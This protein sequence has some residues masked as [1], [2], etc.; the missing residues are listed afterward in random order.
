MFRSSSTRRA[1]FGRAS[2]ATGWRRPRSRRPSCSCSG[3]RR[4]GCRPSSWR[5]RKSSPASAAK[6]NASHASDCRAARW[7]PGSPADELDDVKPPHVS[8]DGGSRAACRRYSDFGT[9]QRPADGGRILWARTTQQDR[10]IRNRLLTR[11]LH[12]QRRRRRAG[13][14]FRTIPTTSTSGMDRSGCPSATGV[15]P[16]PGG[17]KSHMVRLRSRA[18]RLS[19]RLLHKRF[20]RR[21]AQDWRSR[22]GSTQLIRGDKARRCGSIP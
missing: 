2:S 5:A 21:G 1:R 12:I 19:S 14:G 6:G 11:V 9:D 10:S 17:S 8:A 16:R 13:I 15:V 4:G 3:S 18:R 22:D 7:P 20:A